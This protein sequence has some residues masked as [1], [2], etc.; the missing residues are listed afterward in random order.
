MAEGKLFD[1]GF[2]PSTNICFVLAVL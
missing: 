2:F 1:N